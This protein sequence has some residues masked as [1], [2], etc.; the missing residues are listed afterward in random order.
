MRQ[1]TARICSRAHGHHHFGQGATCCG[2]I[3]HSFDGG[4]QDRARSHEITLSLR[5]A[6]T[7][8]RDLVGWRLARVVCKGKPGH[9]EISHLK[10][11]LDQKGKTAGVSVMGGKKICGSARMFQRTTPQ[12]V[13]HRCLEPVGRDGI[14]LLGTLPIG[15]QAAFFIC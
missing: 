11:C 5:D 13:P 1:N 12:M 8:Q 4:H 10:G 7:D 14:A 15:A 9:L 2:V 6:R 3:W